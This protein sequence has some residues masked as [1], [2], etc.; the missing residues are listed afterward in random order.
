MG[1]AAGGGK[2][3]HTYAPAN[4]LATTPRI[5]Y[6]KKRQSVIYRLP[7]IL[8]LQFRFSGYRERASLFLFHAL[9]ST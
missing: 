6:A 7:L 9:F 2:I 5:E 8:F 3:N 1:I 4:R